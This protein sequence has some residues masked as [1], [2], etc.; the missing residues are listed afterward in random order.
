MLLPEADD[1]QGSGR[2]QRRKSGCGFQ[3]LHDRFVD[4]AVLPQLWS[5]MHDAMSDRSRRRHSRAV[6][7]FS[8]A[9]DRIPLARNGCCVAGH[10]APLR[11]P[12]VKFSA[13][14]AD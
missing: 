2:M 5:A 9:V 6:E 10:R 4:Q 3:P 12:F 8:D 7:K 11:I 13:R 14:L 1:G